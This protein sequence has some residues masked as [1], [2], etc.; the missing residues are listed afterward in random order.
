MV[1]NEVLTTAGAV[2]NALGT[3]YDTFCRSFDALGRERTKTASVGRRLFPGIRRCAVCDE[4]GHGLR[5]EVAHI[6]ALEECGLTAPD[7]L[8]LLCRRPGKGHDEKGCH[9]LFDDGFASRVEVTALRTGAE[10]GLT[11]TLRQQMQQRYREHCAP[12]A[13][14]KLDR[15]EALLASIHGEMTR[16]AL[17]KAQHL[18][19]NAATRWPAASEEHFVLKLKTV[20]MMRRRAARGSLDDAARHFEQL[21]QGPIP[22]ARRSSFFYEGGY[23][24]LLR[25]R[26]EKALP[27]FIKSRDAS[28]RLS[29]AESGWKWA[30]AASLAAQ[31]EVAVGGGDAHWSQALRL[32]AEAERASTASGGTDGARWVMNSRVNRARILL[33][34][35]D[36][37]AAARAWEAAMQTW[38]G[39]TALTGWDR[40]SRTVIVGFAGVLSAR[41]ARSEEDAR[42]ALRYLA[43][44]SVGFLGTGRQ[45]PETAR[46]VLFSAA[47]ALMLLGRKELAAHFRE[48]AERTRDGSSWLNPYRV[49]C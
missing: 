14:S 28:I 9:Q 42:T 4:S 19:E 2:R 6:H 47:Q 5:V 29:L 27:Y 32:V 8:I 10:R 23:V 22:E 40:G 43:R 30:A 36:K 38:K 24:E 18:A 48:T 46:D 12:R 16:G 17:R 31:C 1:V 13:T 41:V 35:G 3:S 26:H 25:G 44:A 49:G 11:C 7:N 37:E 39:M 34:K 20:E 33:A 45:H 21:L 15:F